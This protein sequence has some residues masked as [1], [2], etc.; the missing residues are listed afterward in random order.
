MPICPKCGGENPE[1]GAKCPR[2]EYYFVHESALS[3]AAEDRWIGRLAAGK[4]VVVGRISKGGMGAVYRA[5]QLPVQREIALKVLLTELQ[6]S[7][8]G[9]ERFAR[10]ARAIS[11]L[12]HPNVIAMHDFGV[13][14]DGHPFMAMEYAPGESLAHWM[15]TPGLSLERILHV[16]RQIL[17]ALTEAHQRGVVHRDLKPENLIVTRAGADRDFIKL[18]DFGIARMIHD[19]ATRGLTRDGEVFGTPHYMSPEQARGQK[20]IGPPADVYSL[21]IMLF[22]L[23]T[24]ECPFD[25]QRPLSI[26]YMHINDDLPP[27]RPKNRMAVPAGV[28]DVLSKATNKDPEARYQDA[29]EMLAAFNQAT[30]GASAALAA[31]RPAL[32]ASAP[33]APREM[34]A[35]APEPNSLAQSKTLPLIHEDTDEEESAENKSAA[36]LSGA[37]LNDPN[38]DTAVELDRRRPL[39]WFVAVLLALLVVLGGVWIFG[40]GEAPQELRGAAAP[41]GAE[42]E[43]EAPTRGAASV[44]EP[45]AEAEA[46]APA[47]L[48]PLKTD[49]RDEPQSEAKERAE[50]PVEDEQKEESSSRKNSPAS[51]EP[52]AAANTP[53]ATKSA[54]VKE[55]KDKQEREDPP[56]RAEKKSAPRSPRTTSKSGDAGEKTPEKFQ[57]KRF[58][59]INAESDRAPKKFQPQKWN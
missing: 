40:G 2:D 44:E 46:G 51:A 3:D 11:R 19:S 45:G 30:G 56:A 27:V 4:Y 25:A 18:L 20:D 55:E 58:D 32:Q 12:T 48:A 1:L 21:G 59:K 33:G 34:N 50:R 57:P 38:L 52:K 31:D 22:E 9:K 47:D 10:E 41:E 17:A 26:L 35:P 7:E 37:A 24:G 39:P 6:D 23:L 29:G 13:D 15:L 54:P 16:F 43:V 14:E 8:Q 5:I 53:G 42:G 36:G 28:L 49:V